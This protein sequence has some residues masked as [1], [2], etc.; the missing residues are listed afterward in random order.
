[1]ASM[2]EYVEPSL[3]KCAC[4]ATLSRERASA[5]YDHVVESADESA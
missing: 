5:L 4:M 1:M 2:I 3:A